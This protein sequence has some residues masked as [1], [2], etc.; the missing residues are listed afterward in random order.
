MWRK[1]ISLTHAADILKVK[2]QVTIKQVQ[3]TH[4]KEN[5]SIRLPLN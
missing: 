2:F 3:M 4:L 1:S 5:F